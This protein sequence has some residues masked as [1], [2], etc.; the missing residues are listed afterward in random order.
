MTVRNPSMIVI[1]II[2]FVLGLFLVSPIAEWMLNVVGGLAAV[3]GVVVFA[4]GVWS[5]ARSRR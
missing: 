2:I 5:A 3:A 4:A 1:G